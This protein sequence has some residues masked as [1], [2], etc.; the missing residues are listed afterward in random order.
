MLVNSPEEHERDQ[1]TRSGTGRGEWYVSNIKPARSSLNPDL[2]LVDRGSLP[3]LRGKCNVATFSSSSNGKNLTMSLALERPLA[4]CHRRAALVLNRIDNHSVVPVSH[5]V[6]LEFLDWRVQP[7][8]AA[9]ASWQGHLHPGILKE[10]S[11]ESHCSCVFLWK[12]GVRHTECRKVRR[13]HFNV[14]L[15]WRRG[16][17]HNCDRTSPDTVVM[18]VARPEVNWYAT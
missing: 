1:Q 4:P 10:T 13:H 12:D 9:L 6:V 16:R 7:Y 2:V 5:D 15:S 11:S 3:T 8:M 14:E 17:H 18:P